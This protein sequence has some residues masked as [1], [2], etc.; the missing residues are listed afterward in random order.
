MM[1][2]TA[3][4]MSTRIVN[5]VLSLLIQGDLVRSSWCIPY[6]TVPVQ[7][8]PLDPL[9]LFL[10]MKAHAVAA[11]KLRKDGIQVRTIH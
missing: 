8:V 11:S 10:A 5:M 3:Q 7:M 2:L 4:Y 6:S 1:I 9:G